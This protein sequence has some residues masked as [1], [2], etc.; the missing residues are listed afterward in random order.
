[1]ENLEPPVTSG[2][3]AAEPTPEMR[4]SGVGVASFVMALLATV[5]FVFIFFYAGYKE[6]TQRGGMT[7]GEAIFV[8]LVAILC[9]VV[10]LVGLILGIV[11]LFQD[12]RRRTFAGI[13]VGIN[14]VVGALIAAV[15]WFGLSQA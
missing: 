14:V 10:I 15:F 4:H 12:D 9:C 7:E 13:G 1:M 3:Q 5:S 6:T 8:G 2:V 11:G